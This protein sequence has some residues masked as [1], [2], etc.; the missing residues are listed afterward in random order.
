MNPA[1][2]P[3]QLCL[4]HAA[5]IQLISAFSPKPTGLAE[6]RDSGGNPCA[7]SILEHAPNGPVLPV[8]GMTLCQSWPNNHDEKPTIAVACYTASGQAIQ[9][10]GH[11]LLAAA[12]SWQ[13]KLQCDELTLL[14]NN[15]LVHS[16]REQNNT[17]LRFKRLPTTDLPVP[18]WIAGI[19]PGLQPPVAAAVSGDE[20]GY[21]IL[22]WPDEFGLKQLNPSLTRF[23]DQSQRALICTSAHPSLGADT[24]QLRYFAPQYGVDEDPATGSAVRVLA[25]YWSNR[26][27]SL[28]ALQCSAEEGLLLARVTPKHVEVG[29]RCQNIPTKTKNA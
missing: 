9:C 14:M 26:F 18:K 11:G 21:I 15:S 2:D 27:N 29:G 5:C 25:D 10:C 12:H 28:T 22:Q 16:W 20:Q 3:K 1:I 24:V 13:Q 23:S 8:T 4:E 6:R 17:W 7:L 19:F